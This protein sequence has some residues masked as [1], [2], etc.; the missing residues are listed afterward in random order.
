MIEVHNNLFVGSDI[1]AA[2]IPAGWSVLHA[3]KEPWH[4]RAVGY[5]TRGAPKGHPCY[6]VSRIGSEMALNLVDAVD[7]EFIIPSMVAAGVSFVGERLAAGDKVLCH[8][9][10]GQSRGPGIAFLYL[11]SAGI[12]PRDLQSAFAEFR[13][14][15]PA[16]APSQGMR[17]FIANAPVV[18]II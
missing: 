1:D 5:T 7:A 10:Q 16:F 12:L 2:N 13:A 17:E 4:R 8:C 9:N 18:C 11:M 3:A 6:L 15:Y 14:R